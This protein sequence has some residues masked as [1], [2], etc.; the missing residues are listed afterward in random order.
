[1]GRR[2]KGRP[3]WKISAFEA[4]EKSASGTTQPL[5]LPEPKAAKAE[6]NRE[7]ERGNRR[8]RFDRLFNPVAEREP[9]HEEFEQEDHHLAAIIVLHA[10][11]PLK[12]M[13][14]MRTTLDPYHDLKRRQEYDA[15]D[16]L[17]RKMG[18]PTYRKYTD[19]PLWASIR[20]R[21]LARSNGCILCGRPAVQVHHLRY[22]LDVLKGK[23]DSQLVAIC[24]GC[25][26]S[27][28][29]R[30]RDGVKLSP[31]QVRAKLNYLITM[32]DRLASK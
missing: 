1:M 9:R 11:G 3:G 2:R 16:H 17:I 29:F 4:R 8:R 15:R 25:H 13:R 32:R 5:P 19:S 18:F 26:R 27:I 6:R 30:E 20:R 10:S 7:R 31:R 21:V 22:T 28:E 23:D 12:P 14:T 24:R